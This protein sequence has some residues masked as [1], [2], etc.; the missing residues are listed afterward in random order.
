MT[1]N[2]WYVLQ[3]SENGKHYAHAFK[4]RRSENL[5]SFVKDYP[6]IMTMNACNTMEEA[7]WL[8]SAWNEQFKANGTY[9]YENGPF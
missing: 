8:A 3:R 5:A 7:K 2:V 6:N 4:L 1:G 9:L